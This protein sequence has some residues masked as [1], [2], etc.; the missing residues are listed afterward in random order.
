MS[1][2]SQLTTGRALFKWR[3]FTPVPMILFVGWLLWR[4]RGTGPGPAVQWALDALGIAVALAGQALRGYVLGQ[5]PEGTSGQGN[6][7]EA[8]TLNT[9]GPYARV[10][11]PLYVGNALIVMGLL[12]LAQEP[13]AAA[14]T[15]AFFFGQYWFIIRAEE[16]FL[17]GLFHERFDDYCRQ[18]P[19]WIPRLTPANPEKLSTRFDWRRALR[20]EHNPCAAWLTGA[21]A[22]IGFQ[23]AFRD[24]AAFRVALPTLLCAQAVVAVLFV[25]VKGW[26]HQWWGRPGPTPSGN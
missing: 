4:A 6:K 7:L 16:N 22:L 25:G 15:L 20:K 12:A 26:K 24:E 14:L 17:R 18:V 19:R 23:L 21:L 11:N 8:S 2:P 10:R 5:V 13:V 1:S 9:A 3:S